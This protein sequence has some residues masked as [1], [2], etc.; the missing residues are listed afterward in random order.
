[1]RVD[2]CVH[3]L[4]VIE[5]LPNENRWSGNRRLTRYP[6][7]L[8]SSVVNTTTETHQQHVP[9]RDSKQQQQQHRR[10]HHHESFS[11][12]QRRSIELDNSS[13]QTVQRVDISI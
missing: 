7:E 2:C 12:A 3:N 11:R 1:M 9:L 8:S 6:A 5:A 10:L 13:Y 4:G